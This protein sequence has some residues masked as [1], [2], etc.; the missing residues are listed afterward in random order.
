MS[1]ETEQMAPADISP[2]QA[3]EMRIKAKAKAASAKKKE[4]AKK[5][6]K[7]EAKVKAVK[8]PKEPRATLA[9]M[10][11][12]DAAKRAANT[13]VPK[14]NELS[15]VR[16]AFR[17]E[18]HGASVHFYP[19]ANRV[20]VRRYPEIEGGPTEWTGKQSVTDGIFEAKDE[21]A[22]REVA[23]T[24]LEGLKNQPA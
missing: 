5:P 20:M 10:A 1:Q 19:Q 4:A 8:E 15:G 24:Y 11:P 13:G 14:F 23:Q 18:L 22:A 7:K 16:V 17:V 21:D 9:S 3:K 12:L 2:A 6:A